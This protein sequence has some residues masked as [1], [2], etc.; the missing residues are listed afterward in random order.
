MNI[1]NPKPEPIFSLTPITVELLDRQ[2]DEV[3]VRG[4]ELNVGDR[5]VITPMTRPIDYMAIRLLEY[6][7]PA[8]GEVNELQASG[9]NA[10]TAAESGKSAKSVEAAAPDHESQP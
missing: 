4:E 5:L 10:F 8:L 6:H 2:A 7:Q 3:W 9:S 1:P